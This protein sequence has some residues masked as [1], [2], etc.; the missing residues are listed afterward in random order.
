[1]ED[2]L[3]E[4]KPE[5]RSETESKASH[6]VDPSMSL[7]MME[8]KSVPTIS[9]E[10][11]ME[12]FEELHRCRELLDRY[13]KKRTGDKQTAKAKSDLQR[14]ISRIKERLVVGN[15]RLVVYLANRYTGRGLSLQDLIQEGNLGL[16]RSIDKFDYR[17]GCKFSTYASWWIRQAM[18]KALDQKVHMIRVPI[19]MLQKLRNRSS[20]KACTGDEHNPKESTS[21]NDDSDTQL[22]AEII[23]TPLSMNFDAEGTTQQF[24]DVIPDDRPDPE[25]ISVH[26]NLEDKLLETLK[27]LS[28]NEEFILKMRYGIGMAESH[29]LSEIGKV[30]GISK[31]RIRQIQGNATRRLREAI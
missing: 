6:V 10:E 19:Y 13:E 21:G 30:L 11:M 1:M 20:E 29:T 18:L 8:V 26:R 16:M 15:L 2:R 5:S 25:D 27:T 17:R 4:K 7:Y 22:V 23:R 24:Q 31:E 12:F 9:H 14:D 28:H 3:V